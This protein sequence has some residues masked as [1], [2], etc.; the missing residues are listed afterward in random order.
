MRGEQHSAFTSLSM[1]LQYGGYKPLDEFVDE[2]SCTV[3]WKSFT[4]ARAAVPG[5]TSLHLADDPFFAF[6]V[7]YIGS[8]CGKRDADCLS[9]VNSMIVVKQ[10]ILTHVLC[11]W[12]KT[13]AHLDIIFKGHDCLLGTR[14]W[15]Y[16]YKSTL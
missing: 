13:L 3:S 8:P 1:L 4:Q 11:C 7:A 6:L 5:I 15:N 9:N 2:E 14:R 12:W 16:L 10:R